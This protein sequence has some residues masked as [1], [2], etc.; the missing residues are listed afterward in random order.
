MRCSI[1]AFGGDPKRITVFGQSAGGASV[2]FLAYGYPKDPII[3]AIIPQSGTA[4]NSVRTASPDGPNNPAVQNWSQLSQQLGCG[5][6]PYDDV[7]KT[8][9]CMRSKPASAVLSA[10]APKSSG[11]ALKAWGPKLDPKTG[12]FGDM[13]TRGARG[14]FAKV[15]S[16]LF[17][18]RCT[19]QTLI[20]TDS[21]F[22]SETSTMKAH[23][24]M[25][26]LVPRRQRR[27]TVHRTMR[28]YSAVTKASRLGDIFMLESSQITFLDRAAKMTGEHGQSRRQYQ[29]TKANNLPG[30]VQSWL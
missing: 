26:P 25:F 1:E 28:H 14:E 10:T 9:S 23:L 24:L 13:P 21:P 27:P 8:L 15:V 5:A 16:A 3:N 12:V 7:K 19:M 2:D 20:T 18:I 11:D 29:P 4:G 30:T 22:L 17:Q 6:V